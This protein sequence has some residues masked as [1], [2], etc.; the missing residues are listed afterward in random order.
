MSSSYNKPISNYINNDIY[1]IQILI[2]ENSYEEL[3]D[4]KN[5]IKCY[6]KNINNKLDLLLNIITTQ[7]QDIC[8]HEW[9]DVCEYDDR[10]TYCKFCEL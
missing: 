2:K 8:K 5:K 3:L 9:V 6:R 1:E 7:Q 10:Y 4:L